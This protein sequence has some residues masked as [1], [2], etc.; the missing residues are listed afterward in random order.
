MLSCFEMFFCE[1]KLLRISNRATARETPCA[2]LARTCTLRA[3]ARECVYI[4]NRK[5]LS[6]MSTFI[7]L[8]VSLCINFNVIPRDQSSIKFYKNRTFNAF[9]S[10]QRVAKNIKNDFVKEFMRFPS[11]RREDIIGTFV[12]RLFR[13][14]TNDL[15][16]PFSLLRFHR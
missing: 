3:R 15:H 14:T 1:K 16:D 7:H 2:K 10:R 9:S 6:E 11:N 12:E 8:H 13:S 5:Y 4:L